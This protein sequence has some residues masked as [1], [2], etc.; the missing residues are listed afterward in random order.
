MLAW[1]GGVL[2]AGFLIVTLTLFAGLRRVG[3]DVSWL[4]I[5][6]PGRWER[7]NLARADYFYHQAVE[8]FG[9]RDISTTVSA[10]S[11]AAQYNPDHFAAGMMLAQICQ[12]AQP[13]LANRTYAHLL[14]VHSDRFGSLAPIW[15]RSL[16]NRGD[17]TAIEALAGKALHADPDRTVT[18]LHALLFANWHTGHVDT[19][20]LLVAQPDGLD[21]LARQV[22]TMEQQLRA[23]SSLNEQRAF[24]RHVDGAA[25]LPSYEILYR[26]RRLLQLGAAT[27]ALEWLAEYGA[28]L[29]DRDRIA[30]QLDAYATLDY[31][32]LRRAL[33]GRLL[34]LAGEPAIIDLVSAHLIRFPNAEI[35]HE[36][37]GRTRLLDD[38]TEPAASDYPAL[39][40]LYCAAAAHADGPAL[41]AITDRIK[42]STGSNFHTLDAVQH[43]FEAG[44]Q[45]PIGS[46]VPILNPPNLDVVY[47]LF[48]RF[49]PSS[50]EK[51]GERKANNDR[52]TTR[53]R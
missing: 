46:V 32:R 40:T 53:A 5:A 9:E 42:R 18:W 15:F 16:L 49:T 19:I 34:G 45:G 20:P 8:A 4:D 27:D 28:P 24:L 35:F 25:P 14:E 29:N 2:T 51:T 44:A 52:L 38:D 23:L 39:I 12:T 10:L 26:S 17:F 43:Y 3:Y 13:E 21:P 11:L 47:A 48:D 7:I 50:P 31:T 36:F 37:L 22:L 41:A 33:L 1:Q 30:V 6:W